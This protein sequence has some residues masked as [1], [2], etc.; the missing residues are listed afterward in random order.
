M[1]K[2][3]HRFTIGTY[4]YKSLLRLFF[5]FL[6]IVVLPVFIW[7]VLTQRI[8][9]KKR[10]DTSS[11]GTC[12]NRV[13]QGQE[14]DGTSGNYYWPSGC[15][16][17]PTLQ[18][19][20]QAIVQLSEEE[21][22]TYTAWINSGKPYIPNCGIIAPIPRPTCTPRSPC[23]GDEFGN[24]I[25]DDCAY[26]GVSAPLPLGGWYCLATPTPIVSDKP[27]CVSY[28]ASDT[29]GWYV[30]GKLIRN[31]RCST[32]QLQCGEIG[33]RSEGWYDCD[34]RLIQWAGCSNSETP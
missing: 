15:K 28:G 22:Y 23:D 30:K 8:E 21:E 18:M 6:F 24:N 1:T 34:G 33:T 3:F 31:V 26:V 7:A 16:G 5:I 29:E 27:Y 10:T 20:T 4:H 14:Q 11:Q 2:F 12:W 32:C 17:N 9:F 13:Q 25:P 19:C